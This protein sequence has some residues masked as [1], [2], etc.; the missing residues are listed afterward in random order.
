[1]R[2]QRMLKTIGYAIEKVDGAAGKNT[3]ASLMQYSADFGYLPTERFPH[4]FF[5]HAALQYHLALEHPDWLDIFLSGDVANWV[6]TRPERVRREIYAAACEKPSAAVQLVRR[7]KFET[8]KPL[9]RL[10]PETGIFRSAA[11]RAAVSLRIRIAPGK[12]HYLVKLVNLDERQEAAFAFIRSGSVLALRLPFGIYELKYASGET[13]FGPECLF[14][15]S[16]Q[17]GRLQRFILLTEKENAAA[18]STIELPSG[19][20]GMQAAERISEFDF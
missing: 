10:L 9:P 8:Y 13:W 18:T 2:L 20:S 5:E 11:P 4:C 14:G 19:A 15:S 16:A 7:Y 3:A 12:G 6:E 17:Y 1:M